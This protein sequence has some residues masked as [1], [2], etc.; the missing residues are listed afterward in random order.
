ME[1]QRKAKSPYKRYAKSPYRYSD[2][3]YNWRDT[4][5]PNERRRRGVAHARAMFREK[6]FLTFEFGHLVEM[7][8]R[9]FQ[10]L[11][12]EPLNPART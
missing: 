1:T 10:N 12:G 3:Y 5:N 7:G 9:D 8:A 11:F 4:E 6:P 2:A